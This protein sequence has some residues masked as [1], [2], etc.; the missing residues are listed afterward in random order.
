MD[1][2]YFNK[3]IIHNVIVILKLILVLKLTKIK[4]VKGKILR[5][6]TKTHRDNKFLLYNLWLIPM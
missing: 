3:D 2:I 5:E 6:T 4:N 1:K